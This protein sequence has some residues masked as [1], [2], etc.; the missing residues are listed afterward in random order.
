MAASLLEILLAELREQPSHAAE[1]F[2]ILAPF[3]TSENSTTELLTVEQAAEL[4]KCH[5]ETIRRAIRRGHLAASRVGKQ[6]RIARNALEAWL[7]IT[8]NGNQSGSKRS[9]SRSSSS[10]RGAMAEAFERL[11]C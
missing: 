7:A 6:H 1:L 9:R 11:S 10:G 5:P 2:E 3:G 8:P 4:A